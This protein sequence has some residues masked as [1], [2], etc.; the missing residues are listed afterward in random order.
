LQELAYYLMSREPFSTWQTDPVRRV[1]LGR[2]TKLLE[3]YS[4]TPVTDLATGLPRPNVTRGFMRGSSTHPG[5]VNEHWLRSFYHLFL[6]YVA[7]AGMNDEEDEDVI[8]PSG[9]VPVMTMHQS[10]G[11]EFPF[12]FVGHMG[13][14]ANVGASHRLETL[15]SPYP[16]NPARAFARRPE[17]ERAQMDLI[18]QYYVAYSRAEYALIFV[19]TTSHFTKASIPCGPTSGWLRQ[20][21]IPL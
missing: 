7:A 10:K 19:G 20:R 21:T 17:G 1:R 13:E 15:F 14:T 4:S 5:E 8:C 16:A 3:S 12:V 6:T 2:I 18:R 9:M 11:L